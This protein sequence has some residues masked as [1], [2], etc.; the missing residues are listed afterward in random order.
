MKNPTIIIISHIAKTM[1]RDARDTFNNTT[2]VLVAKY[3][4]ANIPI[5][6][7]HPS[8]V[9]SPKKEKYFFKY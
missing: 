7:N 6:S 8:L 5:I 4:E 9:R 1:M 2:A 3:S